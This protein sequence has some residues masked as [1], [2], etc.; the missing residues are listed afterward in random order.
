MVSYSVIIPMYNAGKTIERCL[1]SV[2]SQQPAEILLADDGSTDNTAEV[3]ASLNLPG[4]RII[5]SGHGGASAA[6]NRG[7]EAAKGDWVLFLDA[8]DTLLPEAAQILTANLAKE[9]DA[10]C[11]GI[12]RGTEK[13]PEAESFEGDITD[14]H[15]M[16]NYVLASPTD[17]LTIHG[18]I[19]RRDVLE[20]NKLLFNEELTMGEDSDFVLRV[21]AACGSVRFIRRPVYRYAVSGDSSINSWKPGITDSYLKSLTTIRDAGAG[22][23]QNWPLFVLTT[24]LLILTHDTFHPA[25]P[26]TKQQQLESCRRLRENPIFDEALHSADFAPLSPGKK[27]TLRCMK[28]KCYGL[29]RLAI[30]LRQRQ[31]ASR[32]GE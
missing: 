21:L 30:R 31:N 3:V 5:R 27:T 24:L 6:R 1:R 32:T 12:L 2:V 14:P 10:V 15:L 29:V 16:M 28:A 17:R 11:G 23:E 22:K 26:E 19:F 13:S 8:D 18:W 25:S 4:V 7:L 20:K 9:T